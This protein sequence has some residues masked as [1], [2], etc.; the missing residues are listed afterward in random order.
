L[1]LLEWNARGAF[2]KSNQKNPTARR[3][4]PELSDLPRLLVF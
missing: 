1:N 3:A 2:K 4:R